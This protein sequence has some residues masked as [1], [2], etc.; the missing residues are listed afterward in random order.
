MTSRPLSP[1]R[2]VTT[3]LL[4]SSSLQACRRHPL[5]QRL[6]T[7]TSLISKRRSMI[8]QILPVRVASSLRRSWTERFHLRLL[9]HRLSTEPRR[10]STTL[11][12]RQMQLSLRARLLRRF[13]SLPQPSRLSQLRQVC[14]HSMLQLRQHVPESRDADSQ[15]L[16]V[17]SVISLPSLQ[18]PLT[19][20]QLSLP[21]F[22][23]Q[24]ST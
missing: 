23:R 17:R 5:L 9:L 19:T 11:R 1:S 14:F 21:K 8:S 10:C 13:R 16:P 6:S 2:A 24:L 3:R 22:S 7:T 12:I 20:S 18:T 4:Q 15:L